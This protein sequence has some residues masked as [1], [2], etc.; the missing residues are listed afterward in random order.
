MQVR[1]FLG[2][3]A[4]LALVSLLAVLGARN[5]DLLEAPFRVTPTVSVPLWAALAAAFLGGLL[6]FLVSFLLRG[7]A[8]LVQRW[9]QLQGHRAGR[10]ARD[11]YSRGVDAVLEGREEK[12]LEHFRT[13]LAQNP[14]H[15]DALVKIGAV[16]RSLKRLPEAV[17]MHKAAHRLRQEDLEPLYELVKDYEAQH[18]IGKA[19]VVLNRIVELRPRRAL[20]A[21]RKL[22]KLAMQEG[23]WERACQLQELV[24]QR[25][26]KDSEKLAAEA[27]YAVGIRYE[28]ASRAASE[29]R[30]KEALGALRR[31]LRDHPDF[32]P[33]HLRVGEILRGLG[34]ADEAIQT[35]TA[36]FEQTGSPAFL[37]RLEEHFL[38]EE[39]PE[40][41]IEAL[42]NAVVRSPRKKDGL[43]RLFLAK[44]YLRLEMID[45]AHR[46][47]RTLAAR[48]DSSPTLHAFLGFVLERRG[49]HR[50]AAAEYRRVVQDMDCMR[51]LYR[52]QVC[53]ERYAGWSERCGT[54]GEWNEIAL[55]F[56]EDPTLEEM[57]LSAR[58]VYS[59]SA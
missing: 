37:V 52:C 45:E 16:L 51:L 48:A 31:I 39:H 28:M 17:E 29:G 41:A 50:E 46:E 8:N 22:R 3:L 58:P 38:R 21:Y 25:V 19:K 36:G 27:R 54:C 56:G 40:G 55:D 42:Q 24:E 34:S 44:L 20:S 14:D 11:Q 26:G 2:I 23:D 13:V 15:F 43:A 47:L 53:E 30:Q 57:G 59:R 33:A 5:E 18:E 10:A 49:Q 35:W 32:A 7:S 6:T 1:T 12:A 4:G 9:R